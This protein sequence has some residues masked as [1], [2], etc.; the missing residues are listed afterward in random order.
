MIPRRTPIA[1]LVG[2]ILTL[3]AT[4][5][6]GALGWISWRSD[7]EAGDRALAQ[8]TRNT[9]DQLAVGLALPMWNFDRTQVEKVTESGL[10]DHE[11]AGVVVRQRDVAAPAGWTTLV[12][13]RDEHGHI[14][15]ATVR[16]SLIAE[17]RAV[18]VAGDTLGTVVVFANSRPLEQRLA[19]SLTSLVSRIAIFDLVLVATLFALLWATVLRPLAW[20]ERYALAASAGRRARDPQAPPH[21]FHGEIESLRASTERTLELMELRFTALE[22][23]EREV[24]TLNASLE[25]RVEERT[26]ELQAANRELEAF[27]YSVSH[28]LRAPLRAISGFSKIA[29]RGARRSWETE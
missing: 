4:L 8:H 6:L 1:V 10:A 28:D 29:R 12:R 26:A 20:L 24:R 5:W 13:S 2:A 15:E 14:V 19:Q 11:I 27:S 17:R 21:Q 3:A 7:R 18:A 25:R 23:H 16:D 22:E 9:A